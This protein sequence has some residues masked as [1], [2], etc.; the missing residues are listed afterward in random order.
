[1]ANVL[2]KD[3]ERLAVVAH[4]DARELARLCNLS[5]RQLERHFQRDLGRTPQNWLNE[6][7]LRIAELLLLNGQPVK[8]VAYTL[9]FKQASHF[10]RRFKLQHNLTPSQFVDQCSNIFRVANR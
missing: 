4:F 8:S 2:V 9:G 5:V 7:R 3:L 1:M 10:C 6:L